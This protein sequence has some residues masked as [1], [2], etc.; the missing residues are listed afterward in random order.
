M[1]RNPC[2]QYNG[3]ATVNLVIFIYEVCQTIKFESLSNKSHTQYIAT[4]S[5]L[6]L[7]AV[8]SLLHNSLYGLSRPS[9]LI[10]IK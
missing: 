2:L 4:S 9:D 3:I 7:W 5:V 1:E 6:T 10:V 8:A